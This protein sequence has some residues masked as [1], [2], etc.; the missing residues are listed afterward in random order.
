MSPLGL[1]QPRRE[2]SAVRLPKYCGGAAAAAAAVQHFAAGFGRIA[3]AESADAAFFD[4][5]ITNVRLHARSLF[6]FFHR[7][8]VIS[9]VG[10]YAGKKKAVKNEFR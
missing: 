7:Q 10:N 6:L 5:G 2:T 3:F 8:A 9:E 4:F 1:G